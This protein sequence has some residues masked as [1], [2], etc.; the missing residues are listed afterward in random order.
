MTWKEYTDPNDLN[1][2]TTNLAVFQSCSKQHGPI[3]VMITTNYNGIQDAILVG[4]NKYVKVQRHC[5]QR[6]ALP[7]DMNLCHKYLAF[8]KSQKDPRFV[9]FVGDPSTMFILTDEHKLYDTT[10]S[11]R[12]LHINFRYNPLTL[13]NSTLHMSGI[14]SDGTTKK[15]VYKDIGCPPGLMTLIKQLVET[16]N[17]K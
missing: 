13:G 4:K 16:T 7:L 3:S 2:A 5:T 10:G 14:M 8:V 1:D 15:Q 11:V 9:H 12:V 17:V 6:N